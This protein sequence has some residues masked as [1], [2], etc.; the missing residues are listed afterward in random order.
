MAHDADHESAAELVDR[1][2]GARLRPAEASVADVRAW[3]LA[4]GFEVAAKGRIPAEIRAAFNAS[5]ATE[6]VEQ[7]SSRSVKKVL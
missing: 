6:R 7:R 1:L 3:A 2:P 5:R 4:N